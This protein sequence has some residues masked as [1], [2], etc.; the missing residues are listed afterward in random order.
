MRVQGEKALDDATYQNYGIELM[1]HVK[2]IFRA[3]ECSSSG[4][5]ACLTNEHKALSSNPSTTKNDI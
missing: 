5:Y 3:G 1:Q 4:Q 2:R